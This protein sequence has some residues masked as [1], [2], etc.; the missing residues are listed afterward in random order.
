MTSI[1]LAEDHQIVREAFHMLLEAQPNLN[2]L[3][4][5]G[6]GLDA[7]HLVEKLKPDILVADMMMPGLPGPELARRVKQISPD[8]KVIMLSM[9]DAE[10]Y[11]IEA[12]KIGVAGYVLKKGSTQELVFAIHQALMG[13][14]YLSP[15]LNQRALQTYLEFVEESGQ[16]DLY[17]S[18]TAREKEVFHLAVEGINNSQIAERLSISIRTVEMHRANLM[19]KLGV[20]SQTEL[21]KFAI[22]RGLG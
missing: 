5:T 21:V 14:V 6:D 8:T 1:V 18:L 20:N 2:V 7:L 4:E 3:A 16:E 22:R 11:V 19:K 13:N 17:D 9:Y 10:S 15:Q 12:L